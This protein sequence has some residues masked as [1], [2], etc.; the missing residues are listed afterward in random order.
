M[1]PDI[2]FRHD[3]LRNHQQQLLQDAYDALSQGK[4]L[5]AHAPTGSGKTDTILGAALTHALK[6]NLTIFFL[7]PKISQ[8]KIALDVVRGLE[9]KYNLGIRAV[10][11]IGRRYAC[12]DETLSDMDHEG[13]YFS[14]QKKR[15]EET[16]SYY[17]NAKGYTSL[18]EAKADLR[19]KKML[20]AYGSARSHGEVIGM[21][22]Q[23]F[24]CPYEWM[25][26]LASV[27]NVIIADYFHLLVP[28]IRQIFLSKIKKSI[29]KSILIVDE[30]HNLSSRIREQLSSTM[31]SFFLK[32]TEKE[33]HSLGVEVLPLERVFEQWA[34][35]QLG[36][37]KEIQI[38]GPELRSFFASL[39]ITQEQ[40]ITYLEH[41]G[42]AFIERN[43]RKSAAL[44]ISQFL[45]GWSDDARGVVRILRKRGT[46]FSLSKRFLDPSP[47][48]RILNDAYASVVMSG[49]LLPLEMHR[50]VLGLAPERSI[51]RQYHSPFDERNQLHVIADN[52]TTRY[53]E[54]TVD[55]YKQMAATIDRIV[56]A[57]VPG[58]ALFFP[59]Y[60]VL[61]ALLPLL[62][63]NPLLVQQEGMASRDV[64]E[65]LRRFSAGPGILCAVQGGSLSEGVDYCNQEIKTAVIVGVALDEMSLEIQALIDYYQE[66]FGKG[67]EYGYLYPGVT[68][69]LQSAGR[70][71]RKESDRVA[72]VFLDERFK[73]KN[74]RVMLG[75]RP[76]VVT[77][78]P[79]KYVREFWRV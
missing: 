54:R 50:D 9:A 52:H 34:N 68:K 42:S 64:A 38:A 26:K 25:I 29:E 8:H 30:G 57:S 11:M 61:H 37:E 60:N 27:S 55:N 46:G 53:S 63:S 66:K 3:K 69:A 16:C 74:Y 31:N 56:L 65:L 44:K 71:M 2:Y 78:E 79:E 1:S 32:R 73:W 47:A 48:T 18:D 33:M 59:S 75:Q 13:F 6:E 12:I 28:D 43:N 67:W 76:C 21:G 40:A 15:K 23:A 45:A 36:P 10:D 19:F 49:T 7:T 17:G 62:K 41:I 20:G 70:G 51:L 4:H 22:E 35:E 58:V 72:V 77:S 39:R 14:C 24:S 5:V